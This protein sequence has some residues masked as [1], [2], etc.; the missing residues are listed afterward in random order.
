MY[1]RTATTGFQKLHALRRCEAH[2]SQNGEQYLAVFWCK[3]LT[4]LLHLQEHYFSGELEKCS[5]ELFTDRLPDASHQLVIESLLWAE[6]DRTNCW[7]CLL[8][9]DYMILA[10]LYRLAQ[11]TRSVPTEQ[12][13]VLQF[14]IES[15]P[16]ELFEMIITKTAGTLYP[17]FNVMT[18]RARTYTMATLS[19]VSRRWWKALTRRR[20]VRCII[21][22]TSLQVHHNSVAAVESV[23]QLQS[24]INNPT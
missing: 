6:A 19:A 13:S 12:L 17:T 5:Q 16:L 8:S 1:P 23:S 18:P 24:S 10:D 4:G 3:S 15:L 22:Q 9:L 14:C 11:E 2:W 20:Y 7:R 21:E